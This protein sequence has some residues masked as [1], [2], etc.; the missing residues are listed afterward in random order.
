M[1]VKQMLAVIVVSSLGPVLGVA[2]FY[3]MQLG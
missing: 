2:V 3:L 1:S